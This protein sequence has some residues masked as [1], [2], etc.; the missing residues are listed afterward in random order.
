MKTSQGKITRGQWRRQRDRVAVGAALFLV[1]CF[2]FYW[3]VFPAVL[4][5]VGSLVVI[6]S[7]LAIGV[8]RMWAWREPER[9][10]GE[11]TSIRQELA[12]LE[13]NLASLQRALWQEVLP[14]LIGFNLFCVG[15]PRPGAYKWIFLVLT[16]LICGGVYL[17]L[18]RRLAKQVRHLRAEMQQFDR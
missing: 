13:G 11:L 1:V 8:R 12:S 7:A 18:Y 2:G 4:A 6:L 14:L 15:L 3:F 17:T 5:R 9:V 16:L 10:D